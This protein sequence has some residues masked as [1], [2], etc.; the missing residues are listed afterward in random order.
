MDLS[1]DNHVK[2]ALDEVNNG[3]H[4]R[5]IT[6]FYKTRE[7][8]LAAVKYESSHTSALMDFGSVPMGN[9]DYV[10]EHM[11]EI[12]KDDDVYLEQ[13]EKYYLKR[14]EREREPD[15]YGKF[16]NLQDKLD[17]YKAKDYDDMMRIMFSI[18]Y[19]K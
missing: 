13:M 19:N 5:F 2:D 10:M 11:K 7:V 17:Y 15:Y 16:L 18:V 6:D 8:C 4:L 12:K 14:K 9:L 1:Y 3:Q